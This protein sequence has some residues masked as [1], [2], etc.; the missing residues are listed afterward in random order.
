MTRENA[1]FLRIAGCAVF[2]LALLHG[3][4]ANTQ[5]N[6]PERPGA[7]APTPSTG[8]LP[9]GPR[10]STKETLEKYSLIGIFAADCSKQATLQNPYVVHRVV[11]EQRVQRDTMTGPTT[12][13]DASVIDSASALV[14]NEIIMSMANDRRRLNVLVHVDGDRWRLWETVH[15][16]GQRL[17]SGGRI[18]EGTRAEMPWFNKCTG[19]Q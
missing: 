6:V 5:G 15:E 17:V 13:S 2:V 16:N 4:A 10:A 18:V 3:S 12:R 11:D 19:Q 9:L 14:P 1:P 8:L 7:V